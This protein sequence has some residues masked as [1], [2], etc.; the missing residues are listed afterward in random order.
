MNKPYFSIIIP[1]YNREHCLGETLNAVKNQEFKDWECIIVDDGSRDR[2]R[3]I[4]DI[5]AAEDSRFKC[6]ARTENYNKGGNDARNYGACQAR[7]EYLVF[8]DSD[9]LIAESFLEKRY[10]LLLKQPNYDLYVF[11]TSVFFNQ[12]GDSDLLWNDFTGS[13]TRDELII[14]FFEQDM[15]W[16]TMG[17]VWKKEFYE[18]TDGWDKESFVYQDWEVHLNALFKYP[19]IHF[20]CSKPDSFYRINQVDGVTKNTNTIFFYQSS[21]KE[22][23]LMYLKNQQEITKNSKLH[24]AFIRLVLRHSLIKTLDKKDYRTALVQV[25]KNWKPLSPVTHLE[26]FIK[27]AWCKSYKLRSMTPILYSEVKDLK[28]PRT[29][30]LKLSFQN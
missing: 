11:K 16:H 6:L 4:A 13:E 19:R 23:R 25:F 24:Q 5:F 18:S 21:L 20:D 3:A 27:V 12:P 22:V 28:F 7:S 1:A 10:H 2:T 15:P 29:T 8:L 9:D 17:V 30:H 26:W 14:R